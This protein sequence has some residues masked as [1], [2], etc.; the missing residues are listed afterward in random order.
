MTSGRV[1]T[2]PRFA[3]SP[4]RAWLDLVVLTK[5]KPALDVDLGADDGYPEGYALPRTISI[6]T[7]AI[8]AHPD[9]Y[10][11][12]VEGAF[13]DLATD[14]IGDAARAIDDARW[15]VTIKG[16]FP[17]P[18]DLG[19]L[20]AVRAFER[21]LARTAGAVAI[22]N[23]LSLRWQDAASL[24]QADPP[25]HL[26]VD[27]WI[28][29]LYDD[30]VG[31]IH[32]RGMAQFARPDVALFDQPAHRLERAAQLL[33]HVAHLQAGG[34][35]YRDGGTIRVQSLDPGAAGARIEVRLDTLD[36]ARCKALAVA[37]DT[38]VV[39]GWPSGVA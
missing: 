28:E 19:H 7:A 2:R 24:A 8:A 1:W 22:A 4:G 23:D 6:R 14:Q 29:V 17:D 13:R 21:F 31:G 33:R 11:P 10:A 12:Y 5:D 15:A 32:T 37:P 27:E 25:E 3:P 34:A 9:V 16:S 35:L 38:L 36:A 26:R 30:E 18:P 39:E 20:Q